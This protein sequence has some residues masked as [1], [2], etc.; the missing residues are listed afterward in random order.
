MLMS[1]ANYLEDKNTV[2]I[3]YENHTDQLF[4]ATVSDEVRP[5][6]YFI[7]FTQVKCRKTTCKLVIAP[8]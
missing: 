3:A 6:I 4:E 2:A 5:K 8:S 7:L 1:Q